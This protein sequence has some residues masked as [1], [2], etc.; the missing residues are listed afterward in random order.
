MEI[1]VGLLIG[2]AIGTTG[3]GGGTLTA[4]ALILLMG[5]D[6]RRAVATALVFATSIKLWTTIAYL[7][8]NQVRFGI[9][10]FLLAGGI[11]GA[12]IGTILLDRLVVTSAND[13]V[14]CGVG[15]VV[16]G[17][18]LMCLLGVPRSANA[19]QLRQRFLPSLAFPIGLES[20]FSSAGSG[21]LGT[22]MLFKFTSLAPSEVVG[23]DLAFGFVICGL[24][25]AMQ[26]AS[27]NCDVGALFRLI[28][29]GIAG[30]IVGVLVAGIVPA[31]LLRKS[32]L[33]CVTGIGLSLLIKG[34]DGI[35]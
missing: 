3:V 31:K 8:R 13:W 1:A 22:V 6:P 25:G 5:Y 35:L 21:A 33:I 10:A 18:A 30:S 4:P 26:A 34:I 28:P 20:G 12:I 14:F 23:T 27:G 15:A 17:S 11:P 32:L 29:A 24:A 16:M 9:L 7:V 2:L 19:L